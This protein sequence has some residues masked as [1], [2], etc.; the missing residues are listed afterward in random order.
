M[1]GSKYPLIQVHLKASASDFTI[2]HN[3]DPP[4]TQQELGWPS[5]NPDLNPNYDCGVT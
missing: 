5:Q 3:N 1:N 2:Q 4:P